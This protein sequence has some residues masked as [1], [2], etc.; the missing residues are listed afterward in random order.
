MWSATGVETVGRPCDI[1][2]ER[3]VRTDG[4]GVTQ[5]AVDWF[6]RVESP[7]PL[8]EP[9]DPRRIRVPWREGDVAGVPARRAM[10]GSCCTVIGFPPASPCPRRRRSQWWVHSGWPHMLHTPLSH[11]D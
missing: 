1:E 8:A 4:Q 9:Q 6:A 5:V 2:I 7:R 3:E 10:L 11:E